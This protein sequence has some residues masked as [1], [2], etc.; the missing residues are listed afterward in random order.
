[1]PKFTKASATKQSLAR[2]N[3]QHEDFFSSDTAVRLGINNHTTD[4]TIL[5]NLS[6]T[7]DLMQEVRDLL[8]EPIKINSAYRCKQVNDAVGSKD[9][10]QHLQGLACDFVCPKFGTAEEIIR[11]IKKA[12]II[13]DQCFDE[14][15]WCHISRKPKGN[16]MMIGFYLLENGKR[17]FKPL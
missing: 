7:A 1:M 14:G 15:S 4:P 13:V 5:K 16:R 10:S 2:K 9:T 8:K 3:F 11:A 6:S 17:K 12:G